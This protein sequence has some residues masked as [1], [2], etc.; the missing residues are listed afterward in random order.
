MSSN[1]NAAPYKKSK[2]SDSRQPL[3]NKCTL[4]TESQQEHNSLLVKFVKLT[5]NA[6]TPTKGSR[7]A[8]GHDLYAAHDCIIAPGTRGI[9]PIDISIEL[10]VGSYGR[11]APR[12]GLAINHSLHTLGGVVDSDYRGTI[13]VIL[14]N[15]GNRLFY[16]KKGDRIAQIIVEKI[17]QPHFVQAESLKNTERADKGFGSSG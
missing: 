1:L 7:F 6:Y 8:A 2:T 5:K 15:L 12:S 17:Y 3:T 13:T 11:I 10:P 9:I 14:M 4:T 16:V